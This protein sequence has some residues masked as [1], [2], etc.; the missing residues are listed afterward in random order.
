MLITAQDD[1]VLFKQR[2]VSVYYPERVSWQ[3]E[4]SPQCSAGRPPTI[5]ALLLYLHRV[6]RQSGA[7]P[8]VQPQHRG[9][10][11]PSRH[12]QIHPVPPAVR[13]GTSSNKPTC[14]RFKREAYVCE[15]Y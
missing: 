15:R 7:S 1:A 5:K 8:A 6:K 12:R 10:D 4:P 3:A 14:N 13:D 11:L 9:V 2:R